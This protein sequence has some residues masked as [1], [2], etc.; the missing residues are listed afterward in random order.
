MHSL[1]RIA[2]LFSVSKQRAASSAFLALITRPRLAGF[3]P[4][5]L[6]SAKRGEKFF[7]PDLGLN[8]R[9]WHPA[10]TPWMLRIASSVLHTLSQTNVAPKLRHPKS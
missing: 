10:K 7:I 1:P 3:E 2:A 8:C 6:L 4:T 9:R 5:M